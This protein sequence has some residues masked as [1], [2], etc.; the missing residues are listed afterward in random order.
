MNEAA[1]LNNENKEIKNLFHFYMLTF[2]EELA[3]NN[4]CIDSEPFLK[5]LNITKEE[6]QSLLSKEKT[7]EQIPISI[8]YD[9]INIG[10]EK[11]FLLLDEKLKNQHQSFLDEWQGLYL[12]TNSFACFKFYNS[13][14]LNN[15]YYEKE[16]LLGLFLQPFINKQKENP[17]RTLACFL[18]DNNNNKLLMKI[19]DHNYL[20]LLKPRTLLPLY[21]KTLNDEEVPNLKSLFLSPDNHLKDFN[22]HNDNE[23]SINIKNLI[24]KKSLES[25][26]RLQPKK[27]K[28]ML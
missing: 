9:M 27:H 23:L 24:Q 12:I 25:S 13:D 10:E 16:D 8:I 4:F 5:L 3:E 19:I 1:V 18:K 17:A 28:K 6:I 2:Q 20:S 7:L 11:D 26:K 15:N 21:I 14:Y 22:L